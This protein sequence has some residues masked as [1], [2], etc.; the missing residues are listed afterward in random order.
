[1]RAQMVHSARKSASA[2]CMY[3]EFQINNPLN[4]LFK[5]ALVQL[6]YRVHHMRTRNLISNCLLILDEVDRVPGSR[7]LGQAVYFNRMNKR[8]YHCYVL[9]RMLLNQTVTIT[10]PGFH[11]GVSIL[12]KMN[13]L[14]EAYIAYIAKKVANDVIVKDTR[15]KLLINNNSR[16]GAFQLEPD[17]FISLENNRNMI[18]DTKWK[19]IYSSKSRHGVKREDFYQMYAYLTRYKEVET[20]VLLYPHHPWISTESGQCLESWSLEDNPNKQLKVFSISYEDE[21]RAKNE[22][23]R[24]IFEN[25]SYQS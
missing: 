10:N 3:D 24:I 2:C 6:M 21:V 13:E 12:F 20:V 1:M 17:L 15:Y 5:A 23:T 25:N 8:F 7:L 16:R 22:L 18:I 9:A 19:M 11:K 14:F 4:Q